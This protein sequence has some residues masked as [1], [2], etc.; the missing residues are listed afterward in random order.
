MLTDERLHLLAE[1]FVGRTGEEHLIVRRWVGSGRRRCLAFLSGLLLLSLL[2]PFDELHGAG[3]EQTVVAGLD[4]IVVGTG[5]VAL[6]LMF[7]VVES[8]EH[9]YGEVGHALQFAYA[10]DGVVA[11]DARQHDVAEKQVGLLRGDVA[12][13]IFPATVGHGTEIF[14]H[15]GLDLF[16]HVGCVLDDGHKLMVERVGCHVLYDLQALAVVLAVVVSLRFLLILFEAIALIV[17]GDGEDEAR[18]TLSGNTLVDE[19]AVVNLGHVV[20][21]VESNA[22]AVVRDIA[23]HIRMEDAL[24]LVDAEPRSVVLH[25]DDELSRSSVLADG[26]RHV[27]FLGCVFHSVGKQVVDDCLY[28][29]RIE[30]HGKRLGE[31]HEVI[32]QM[33][34]CSHSP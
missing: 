11:V 17:V 20:G 14:A 21:R 30:G 6:D 7:L 19:R 15:L 3:D 16:L 33:L 34:L 28:R 29:L 22:H 24:L 32:V 1:P 31:G 4:H 25:D 12:Q 13:R 8:G 23:A 9:D 18:A 5:L 2:P 10:A 26:E 27:T